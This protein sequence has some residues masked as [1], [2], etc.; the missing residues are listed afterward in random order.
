M[1]LGLGA[2]P[3]HTP[4]ASE[5]VSL[6]RTVDSLSLYVTKRSPFDFLVER[7]FLEAGQG[8]CPNFEPRPDVITPIVSL[9]TQPLAPYILLADNVMRSIA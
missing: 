9:F 1:P 2:A 4:G 5:W 8:E 3:E 7:R 6:N